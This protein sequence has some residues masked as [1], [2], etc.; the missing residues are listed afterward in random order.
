[1]LCNI[2]YKGPLEPQFGPIVNEGPL[3][4][5]LDFCGPHTIGRRK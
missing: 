4:P 5:V 2:L 3:R 1:M